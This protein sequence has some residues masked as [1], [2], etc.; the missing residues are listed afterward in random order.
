V[1]NRIPAA[2]IIVPVRRR[3]GSQLKTTIRIMLLTLVLL[4]GAGTA[5]ADPGTWEIQPAP[6]GGFSATWTAPEPLPPVS[7]RPEILRDGTSLGPATVSANS[8]E[9]SIVI[10]GNS[11]P[12]PEDLAV[13]LSGRYLDRPEP[14]ATVSAAPWVP[15]PEVTTELGFDPGRRGHLAIVTSGYSRA[16]YSFAGMRRLEMKGHVVAPADPAVRMNAPLVLFLHGRHSSCFRG[17]KDPRLGPSWPCPAGMKPVPSL[18]GYDYLQR[19]LA[20]QGFVTVAIAANGIN[21]QDDHLA[22]GGASARADLVERHLDLWARWVGSGRREADLSRVILIGHSRGGEGVNRAAEQ[23]PVA[24]PYRIAGQILLAPTDFA[25]QSAAFIPTVTVLPYCD[26]DVSGLD[27]QVYTDASIRLASGDSSL[28]SSVVMFGANHNYF[29]TEWTPGISK[30]ESSDDSWA[31]PHSLCGT[32]SR[33]RLTAPRQRRV[34]TSYVAGA[35]QLMTGREDRNRR[36]F[37]GSPVRVGP[38]TLSP[39]ISQSVGGG[40]VTLVAGRDARPAPERS[41]M[42]ACRGYSGDQ[43][44]D[45]VQFVDTDLTPHWPSSSPPGLPTR[46]ALAMVWRKPGRSVRLALG[47][48]L[49]LTAM[50]SLDLRVVTDPT[51]RTARLGVELID[52]D[53]NA[54]DLAPRGIR[55]VGM[56][57]DRGPMPFTPGRWLARSVQLRLSAAGPADLARIVA[58][59]I[60][61]MEKPSCGT[62][63]PRASGVRVL[64]ISARPDGPL[65]SPPIRRLPVIRVK[66]VTRQ[67][68]SIG[69]HEIQVPFRVRGQ[70]SD[71]AA[72]FRA[73]ATGGTGMI[74]VRPVTVHLAPGTRTGI[75]PVRYRRN[76]PGLKPATITLDLYPVRGAIPVTGS[77][78]VLLKPGH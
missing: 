15:R 27:G 48:Q 68:G 1:R 9:L 55:L 14:V 23:I 44:R 57:S 54:T 53:G 12:D 71:P 61:G 47:R 10:P 42:F 20:S 64:D 6:G 25:R 41:G 75:I 18:R 35:V 63:C 73:I 49:D 76:R 30:A 38:P 29:N 40:K 36:L 78:R 5:S 28:K 77:A 2:V 51:G 59:R 32:R 4:S 13:R 58:L 66:N 8:R 16:P 3:P 17:G 74:E 7:S 43:E 31:P 67:A 56:P 34:A 33:T 45:C 69:A 70:V 62:G 21:G 60:T 19:T 52:A 72:R 65:P 39:V 37:D 22:D 24:A 46:P 50:G 26:G 11:A